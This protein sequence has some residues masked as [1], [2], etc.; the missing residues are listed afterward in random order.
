MNHVSRGPN[1]I[2][3]WYLVQNSFVKDRMNSVW[4]SLSSLHVS[5]IGTNFKKSLPPLY[6]HRMSMILTSTSVC[7]ESSLSPQHLKLMSFFSW[8]DWSALSYIYY[9]SSVPTSDLKVINEVLRGIRMLSVT[10]VNCRLESMC[11]IR[12]AALWLSINLASSCLSTRL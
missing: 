3:R 6:S 8:S 4:Y 12:F 2:Y 7:S 5:K 11:F 1:R 9:L 10:S